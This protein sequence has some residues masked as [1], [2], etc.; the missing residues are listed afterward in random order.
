M[1][2]A[3]RAKIN[4]TLA[5]HGLGQLNDPGLPSQLGYLVRDHEHFRQILAAAEP[6]H[7]REAYEALRANLRFEPKP[8]DV[9]MAETAMDAAAR[10]LPTVDVDGKFHAYLVPEYVTEVQALVEDSLAKGM[11]TVVCRKC[12][13]EESFLGMDRQDA[14]RKAREAGWVYREDREG[15]GLE[16]CPKCP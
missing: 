5:L 4:N 3:L 10:Q 9:Y 16:V 11:L 13:R 15:E 12:T 1:N 2:A 7:R 8:L 6:E 14:I